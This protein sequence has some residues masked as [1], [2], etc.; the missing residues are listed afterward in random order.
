MSSHDVG[1][2]RY[3]TLHDDLWIKPISSYYSSRQVT[4]WLSLLNYETTLTEHDVSSGGFSA[5]LHNLSILMRLHLL[6]FPFE[7]TFMH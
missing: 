1:D 3:G 4:Q 7:N 6:A 5:N 2:I